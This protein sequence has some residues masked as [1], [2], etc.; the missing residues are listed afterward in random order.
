LPWATEIKGCRA[1]DLFAWEDDPQYI[2]H[3]RYWIFD[4]ES[5]GSVSELTYSRAVE[6][7]TDPFSKTPTIITSRNQPE[8]PAPG[9][10]S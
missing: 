7:Q 3:N 9:A 2:G 5:N 1:G 10:A 6:V 4:D 8:G